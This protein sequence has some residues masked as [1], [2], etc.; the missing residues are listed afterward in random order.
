MHCTALRETWGPRTNFDLGALVIPCSNTMIRGSG[1]T[2]RKKIELWGPRN[3]QI[4]HSESLVDSYIYVYFVASFRSN[5]KLTS[6]SLNFSLSKAQSQC[7]Y[8]FL[9]L[10]SPEIVHGCKAKQ[11]TAL[12]YCK[13]DQIKATM[14]KRTHQ[15]QNKFCTEAYRIGL[16]TLLRHKPLEEFQGHAPTDNFV[17]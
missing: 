12:K 13:S 2:P 9:Y 16:L 4:L 1:D 11:T 8:R 17:I 5:P 6:I 15:N 14:V 7:Y 10:S 3:G